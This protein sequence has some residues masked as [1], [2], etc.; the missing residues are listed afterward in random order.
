MPKEIRDGVNGTMR[1]KGVVEINYFF[2]KALGEA[3]RE[4]VESAFKLAITNRGNC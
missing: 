4:A 2:N 3:A 1:G